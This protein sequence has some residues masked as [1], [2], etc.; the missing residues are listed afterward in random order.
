[1]SVAS[2]PPAIRRRYTRQE[3]YELRLNLPFGAP[4]PKHTLFKAPKKKV[5]LTPNNSPTLK[6]E[7]IKDKDLNL[8]FVLAE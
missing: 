1:M 3:L 4:W 8:S 7:V 5:P 6:P 2:T